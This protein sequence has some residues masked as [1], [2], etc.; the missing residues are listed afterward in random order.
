M[1]TF[2]LFFALCFALVAVPACGAE[3]NTQTVNG[4]QLHY[5]PELAPYPVE[6][7][8]FLQAGLTMAYWHPIDWG[9]IHAEVTER[10]ACLAATTVIHQIAHQLRARDDGDPDADHTDSRFWR[11]RRYWEGQPFPFTERVGAWFAYQEC[12]P[13]LLA[14]SLAKP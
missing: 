13:S 3:P 7:V 12:V 11:M 8:E 4:L 6:Q 14:P 5:A 1:R 10:P 2:L 9:G